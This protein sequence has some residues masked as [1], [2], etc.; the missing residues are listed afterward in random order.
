VNGPLLEPFSLGDDP[1]EAGRHRGIDVEASAAEPVVAPADGVVA[2]AGRVPDGGTTLTIETAD[3]Y[4]VTLLH[5]GPLVLKRGDRAVQGHAVALVGPTG[6]PEWDRPYVHLGIRVTAEPEGYVDPLTLLPPRPDAL[7]DPGP[8]GEAAPVRASP[9]SPVTGTAARSERPA[10]VGRPPAGGDAPAEP[11]SVSAPPGEPTEPGRPTTRPAGVPS[12][13]TV[14]PAAAGASTVTAAPHGDV[15][16]RAPTSPARRPIVT[17]PSAQP[18]AARPADAP[19]GDAPAATAPPAASGLPVETTDPAPARAAIVDDSATEAS[20]VEP[21]AVE[22]VSGEPSE[23]ATITA[24]AHDEPP[25]DVV[26][27]TADEV[28]V[29]SAVPRGDGRAHVAK[30]PAASPPVR[31]GRALE[32]MPV[33][34]AGLGVRFAHFRRPVRSFAERRHPTAPQRPSPRGASTH[35][36]QR[37]T[38]AASDVALRSPASRPVSTARVG[39]AHVE[40]PATSAGVVR[41]PMLV[42]LLLALLAVANVPRR[43]SRNPAARDDVGLDDGPG[44][45]PRA[46]RRHPRRARSRSCVGTTL[47]PL[48]AL[49]REPRRR[50]APR[51]PFAGRSG[52]ALVRGHAERR[53]SSG[54]PTA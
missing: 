40:P 3:D 31:V 20:A 9:R 52:R 6:A 4:S 49:L 14:S 26:G 17:T 33:V 38:G 1:Y 39:P 48:T 19:G 46:C 23:P 35:G 22:T 42:A 37:A 11:T 34:A 25:P 44:S 50:P 28:V 10:T 7:P 15:S 45:R 27:P 18:V 12:G 16:G 13:T 24:D 47:D 30:P 36:N 43:R 29:S 5:L 51:T 41:P 2:F 8:P 32:G 21:V 53:R 54:V